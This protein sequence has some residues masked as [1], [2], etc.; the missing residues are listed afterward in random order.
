M[1]DDDAR[2]I[3]ARLAEAYKK[4]WATSMR[5]VPICNSALDV[6]SI[7]FRAH[8]GS[9]VGIVVTPWFMNLVAVGPTR[10]A[11]PSLQEGA[12]SSLRLPAGEVECVDA[13]LDGFGGLRACSLFSPMFD[14]L[15]MAVARTVAEQAMRAF[16]TEPSGD[17]SP[18]QPSGMG[19]RALLT[20]RFLPEEQV[21][22]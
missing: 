5:D 9:V 4:I 19:R 17:D 18:R 11:D 6:E 20:G 8:G 3:G 21:S 13:W 14:F 1:D 7:G 22:P 10:E 16:F 2:A 12:A 15:D